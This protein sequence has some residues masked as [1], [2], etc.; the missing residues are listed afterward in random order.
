[1]KILVDTHVLLWWLSDDPKLPKHHREL[2][3][4][5]SNRVLVSSVS[6]AEISIKASLG[7]LEAPEGVVAA[8]TQSG[9]EVLDFKAAHAERLRALPWHHRDPFDRMLVAQ[10]QEE[11][12]VLLTVD[13]RIREYDIDIV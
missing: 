5:P 3:Q 7:K 13:Q 2:I 1:V 8:V 4:D 12:L 6:I 9:F 10:T 11:S